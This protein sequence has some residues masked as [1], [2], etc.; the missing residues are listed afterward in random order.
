MLR[1]TRL[2]SRLPRKIVGRSSQLSFSGFVTQS[3]SRNKDVAGD[4]K[5][6]P[7]SESYLQIQ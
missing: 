5:S 6:A 4:L 1:L 3:S 7:P 2:G